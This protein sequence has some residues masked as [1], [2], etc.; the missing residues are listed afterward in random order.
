MEVRKVQA[1]SVPYGE[2]ISRNGRTVFAAYYGTELLAVAASS[3]EVR[4][5][6]RAAILARE[7]AE[8]MTG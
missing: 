1:D 6:Y 5:K 7:K 8:R 4:I 3:A 2:Q